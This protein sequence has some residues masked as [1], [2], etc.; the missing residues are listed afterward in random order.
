VQYEEANFTRLPETKKDRR[1]L[2]HAQKKVAQ[3]DVGDLTELDKMRELLQYERLIEQGNLS[4]Y[5]RLRKGIEAQ[6][7]TW[8][9]QK[10]KKALMCSY[11]SLD[12][13]RDGVHQVRK[14]MHLT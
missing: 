9:P 12:I 10:D 14:A 4:T 8:H 3:E 1:Q 2:K 5:R 7:D 6:Q 13:I 11:N